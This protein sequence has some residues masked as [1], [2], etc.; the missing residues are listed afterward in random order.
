MPNYPRVFGVN[1][2]DLVRFYKIVNPVSFQV[3]LREIEI[4]EIHSAHWV[5][6]II[7]APRIFEISAGFLRN[8]RIISAEYPRRRYFKY[9]QDFHKI[10]APRIFQ[11]SAGDPQKEIKL[12]LPADL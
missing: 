12:S 6:F 3:H 8:F 1:T 11:I 2:G 7:S 4:W 9:L 10:S 5:Q